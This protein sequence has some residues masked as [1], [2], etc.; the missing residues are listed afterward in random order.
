MYFEGNSVDRHVF[1]FYYN[2]GA[3]PILEALRELLVTQLTQRFGSLP[4]AAMARVQGADA[5]LLA[6]WGERLI[7]ATSLDDLLDS[8]P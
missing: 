7:S 3:Q 5:K 2:E 1:R 4:D 8:K 6:R